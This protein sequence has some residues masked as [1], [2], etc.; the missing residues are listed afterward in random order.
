LAAVRDLLRCDDVRLV[1]LTGPGGVGKTRLALQV[2]VESEPAFADGAVFV[3]LPLVRDPNLILP[4]IARALDLPDAG[5][6]PL[7]ERLRAVLRDRDLLLVLDNFEQVIVAA[8][9]LIDLLTAC[10]RLKILVTSREVL[11]VTGEHEFP[12]QPLA[13]PGAGSTESLPDLLRHGAVALFVQQAR[14]ARPT[15]ALAKENAHV[16]AAICSRLEGLPLAIELAAVRTRVLSPDEVLARLERRLPLLG[17]GARDLPPRQQTMRNAIAWSYDLLSPDEQALF[18]RLSVFAGGCTLEAAEAIAAAAGDLALDPL[19]GVTSLV[20]KSLLREDDRAG[21]PRFVMLETVREFGAERL[22]A[23]DEA[24]QTRR[25]HAIWYRDLAERARP[26]LMGWVNRTWL[27]QLGVELDNI[28]TALGWAIERD[29]AETAQRFAYTVGW[30][31]YVTDQLSEGRTWTERSLTCAGST[32]PEVRAV[33]LIM[34]GWLAGEQGD[35]ARA[36]PL[37]NEGLALARTIGHRHYEAQAL[38]SLGLVAVRRAAFDRARACFE[39]ALAI[40][41]SLGD[42]TWVPFALKNLGFVAYRRGDR[43]QADA[44][45]EQALRQFRDLGNTFGTAITLIS[46]AKVARD[47]GD[48]ARATALYAEGLALRWDH[49]DKISVAG[50]LRGLALVAALARQDERAARL[51]GAAEALRESIG[52]GEPRGDSRVE[53]ALAP[54]RTA[55]GEEAFAAAWAAGRALPLSEAVAE[56]LDV[57]SHA[58]DPEFAPAAERYGLTAR[59]FEVLGLLAAG[60]TNPEIAE[61]LFIST[62]TAQTHVQNIFAKLGVGTRAEAAAYAAKHGLAP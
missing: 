1:T 49:G 43:A 35:L 32:T 60:R 56:A 37:V 59:E 48:L 34:A 53:D 50:C 6:R 24:A 21:S 29:E 4:E 10:P 62:R 45:Y 55:L 2:A 9:Y 16:V 20:E 61:T 19:E 25:R 30:Y 22:E 57:P 42:V 58:P 3:P 5:D 46:M 41:A 38:I 33:A 54:A 40:H 13:V 18:R 12:V 15:F 23:S 31:W 11:R 39:E 52:A 47:R 26:E 36:D 51:F 7:A 8:P 28:R 27:A 44:L 17:H 14:A